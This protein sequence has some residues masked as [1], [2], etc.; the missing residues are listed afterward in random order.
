MHKEETELQI[1]MTVVNLLIEASNYKFPH[2]P[3]NSSSPSVGV[4]GFGNIGNYSELM[5]AV[6]MKGYRTKSGKVISL[7]R[8]QKSRDILLRKYGRRGLLNLVTDY[9]DVSDSTFGFKLSGVQ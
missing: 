8:F 3:S 5:T 7:S 9:C 6:K 2:D 1:F 4:L